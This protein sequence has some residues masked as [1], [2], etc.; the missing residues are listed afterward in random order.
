MKRILSAL[1]V[2][3][4]LFGACAGLIPAAATR[5]FAADADTSA[6]NYL[7]ATDA[8]I[9][10]TYTSL[11]DKIDN[12]GMQ[13]LLALDAENEN[14]YQLYCNPF[15]GEVIYRNKTTGESLTTNPYDM[16]GNEAISTTVKERLMSQVVVSYKGTDGNLK[17]MYSYTEAAR[18]GQ[19]IVKN[20]RDGIR[21]QY[22]IGRE[23]A[24]YLIPYWITEARFQEK[25]MA[26]LDAYVDEIAELHGEDSDEWKNADFLRNRIKL[27]WVLQDPNDLTQ[28]EK[29]RE[30]IQAL[31]PIT[32]KTDPATGEKYAIRTIPAD[33]TDMQKASFETIIRTF[34]TE[35]T[36]ED[37]EKDNALTGYVSKDETPP[38]F[39]V[40]IE[41]TINRADGSLDI[42]VPANGILYDETMF[43]LESIS[44]LNYL[45]AGRMQ[46]TTYD[47]YFSEKGEAGKVY[48]GAAGDEILYDGYAFYPDGSG[49]L[50]QFSDL[51]T[52]TNKV[53]VTWDSK[54][55]GQD[56]AYYT[57]GGK[58]QE[59]INMP[60]YG[61]VSTT[62]VEEKATGEYA[63]ADGKI[64]IYD[65]VPKKAGFLAILEEGEALTN[66][67]VAFGATRHNYA[68]V[69]PSYL[70]RPKD[71]YDLADSVSVSGNT[72][73]TVV[74]DRK[75]TGSYRTRVILLSDLPGASYA[76]SWVGMA[77]AYRN[78]LKENDV[79]TRLTEGDVDSQIPLY[80]EAFGAYETTKQILSMPVD[81]K[82]P[83][84]T[85]E[86]IGE[87]YN[88]LSE[89]AGISN[90][91]FKL[92]G[93]AN[94]GML[95]RYPAKLKWEKAVGGKREFRELIE[96]AE[97]KGFGVY[98]E[99]D[100]SYISNE[101]SFDGVSLKAL[102]ART[103]D[104]R[105]CSKQIYDAVYQ[106]F[107]N[108]FDMCVATNLIA[109]YYDKFSKKL[110]SYQEDGIFGLSVG[111]L[112]S[113]LNS[114][115]DEDN[116]INREEAKD[117]IVSLISSMEKTYGSLMV[118]SGNSY[119]LKYADHILDMP[120]EGSNYRYA[121]ASVPFMAMILHG[122]IN[123]AGSAL[124]TSGDTD[125]AVL[126]SIE[127]GAYP[128]YLLSYNTE[129]AMLLKKDE[130]LN[131]YYSIRYD[132]WRWS[133]P[134]N[135]EGDGT[136]IEQY[137]M[138]NEALSDLQTAE[139]VDHQFI[140][141]ERVLRD[142]EIAAQKVALE[143]AV[144]A[145]VQLEIDA[146][147][148]Q[149]LDT[150]AG[151]L[152]YYN[153]LSAYDSQIRA[154]VAGTGLNRVKK[155]NIKSL[156]A[157]AIPSDAV[158]D[159]I[160]D[161]YIAKNGD[162]LSDYKVERGLYV[163]TN[164]DFDKLWSDILV[165]V[166][167]TFTAEELATLHAKVM[168]LAN[169]K[170]GV[171]TTA[172]VNAISEKL[173][174]IVGTTYAPAD[175]QALYILAYTGLSD[176]DV[177]AQAATVFTAPLDDAKATMVVALVG[178]VK[179]SASLYTG[180]RTII[181]R[182]LT[183]KDIETFNI[184]IYTGLD[185]AGATAR[186][187]ADMALTDAQ[188][189]AI[190]TMAV[191]A[192]ARAEVLAVVDAAEVN[193]NFNETNSSATDGTN[194][195]DTDFTLEDERLVLVTYRKADGT[196]VKFILNYNIFSVR[197]KLGTETYTL[198]PYGYVRIGAN[199]TGGEG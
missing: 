142:S 50:F 132:I 188:A 29:V 76:P 153:I 36:Y 38:L 166:K 43:T 145:A 6:G 157:E 193:F 72:E 63:D 80:I 179:A 133:D 98:P 88:D 113:D 175:L 94:G 114:N 162:G 51:Y 137:R 49:T 136:I 86:N 84:T 28:S 163:K 40:S 104:N 172:G 71:T 99:F 35:Y 169:T 177:K 116:P 77:S 37:I 146:S 74:A 61:V 54:V 89:N 149:I 167:G 7:E 198:N 2:A 150:L 152:K 33:L 170:D 180:L 21:V 75:Y 164:I 161:T 19:I 14:T 52:E 25:I 168:A 123:Y 8:A 59:K 10:T 197:V 108:Y 147:Y 109:K 112:G 160:A 13:L 85:F 26:P 103:V 69:Y 191:N 118:N 128:Y 30:K 22:T 151:N 138:L 27:T 125:Y 102:G 45:G 12:G 62:G 96:L 73:W 110:S 148:E 79:L 18:R 107:T 34:C 32:K 55:Y 78:Y 181:G 68:S 106:Q 91:N 58:S 67:T 39:K 178:E 134:D 46:T 23:N 41:Y 140:Q 129:N 196:E 83:L 97:E 189:A 154:I 155:N 183:D 82:V 56:F 182:D 101:G 165:G 15:T 143:D 31:Y 120:L 87:I 171:Y 192:R 139:L 20:I 44:T 159:K 119:I 105:Y 100:F 24:M 195:E 4:M 158:R 90:I 92:T 121:S 190:A 184:L 5:A 130:V 70:P 144:L 65:L 47:S 95:S 174:A 64:A 57:I 187:K 176:A 81:V 199:T 131:K 42:R 66:L 111:T 117:D 185:L 141:G 126:K 115:F 60:V 173:A 48:G 53:S 1:L 122:Y 127:N 16:G 17:T 124:N 11:Q 9:S 135:R 3:V 93:F 156:L 194:Y 186:A